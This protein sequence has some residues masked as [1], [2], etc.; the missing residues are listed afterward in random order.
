ML[1]CCQL[2]PLRLPIPCLHL[3]VGVFYM[4]DT[5]TYNTP[6][7]NASS[8]CEGALHGESNIR[9]LELN[10]CSLRVQEEVAATPRALLVPEAAVS[11]LF[12]SK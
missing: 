8:K 4:A 11:E 9:L 12:G 3:E 7:E 6:W 10:W 5:G 2:Q 1:W